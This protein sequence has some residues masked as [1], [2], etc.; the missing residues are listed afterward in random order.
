[1]NTY[2]V[3][4]RMKE[5]EE[6]LNYYFCNVY[7]G[8]LE[9]NKRYLD[10]GN[11]YFI[12]EGANFSVEEVLKNYNDGSC[13]VIF[14]GKPRLTGEEYFLDMRSREKEF[15]SWTQKRPDEILRVWATGYAEKSRQDENACKQNGWLYLDTSFNQNEKLKEF[16]AKVAKIILNDK[17]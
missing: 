4:Y 3:D 9:F 8:C 16:A 14:V 1:M 12:I 5:H 6:E 2:N 15:S 7:K 17:N 13:L 10:D 11:T